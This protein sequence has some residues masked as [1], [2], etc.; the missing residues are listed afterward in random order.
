MSWRAGPNIYR[1]SPLVLESSKKYSWIPTV[2][3]SANSLK[4]S[5]NFTKTKMKR[6][7]FQP[8]NMSPILSRSTKKTK[9]KK[10]RATVPLKYFNKPFYIGQHSLFHIAVD[11]AESDSRMSMKLMSKT[12]T[13]WWLC[14]VKDTSL[15]WVVFLTYWNWWVKCWQVDDSVVLKIPPCSEWCSWLTETYD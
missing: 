7:S 4:Y 15:F 8:R 9:A 14:G 12:L 6:K 11:T 3:Y 13:S 1:I 2:A 10:S 5:N